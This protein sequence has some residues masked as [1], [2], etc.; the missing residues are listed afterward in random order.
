MDIHQF[1]CLVIKLNAVRVGEM[2][3]AYYTLYNTGKPPLLIEYVNPDCSCTWYE[4]S[5]NITFYLE[6]L[7]KLS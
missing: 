7:Y 1:A 5:D 3:K 2:I 6:V 4:V